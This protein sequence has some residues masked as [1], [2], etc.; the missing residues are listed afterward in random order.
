MLSYL[1]ARDTMHQNQWLAAIREL[2]ADGLEETPCPSNFPQELENNNFNYA[3][4]NHSEGTESAQGG[5]ASGPSMDGKG[6]ITYI[7]KPP[8]LGQVQ[9]LGQV[10]PRLFGTPKAPVTAA[11]RGLMFQDEK[12]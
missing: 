5:W 2:E 8:A 12:R 4:L 11:E 3:F 7:E 1:L 10:D 9:D 6:E